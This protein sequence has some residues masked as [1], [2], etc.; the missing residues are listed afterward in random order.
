MT[1]SANASLAPARSDGNSARPARR[2]CFVTA[3][4]LTLQAFMRSHLERF[5]SFCEVTAVADFGPSDLGADDRIAGVERVPIAIPRA[6]SPW[7]DLCALL[8]L[9]RLFRRRRFDVVHSVTPKAGLLAMSAARA[10]GIP[11]R[12]HCFTGQVWATRTGLSRAMLRQADSLIAAQATR[13][14]VDSRSQLDFLEET[15]VL[16]PGQAA[17]LGHGSISG[18]D[19]ERFRPDAAAHA[20]VR[21]ELGVPAEAVLAVF[22]GRVTRD[23]GVLELAEAFAIAGGRHS[24]LWLLLVGPDEQ[25]LTTEIHRRAGPA[26][27]RLRMIAFTPRPERYL[28]AADI[29][30]LPSH[31]EGF[32][33]TVIEAAACG[34]PALA[35]RI[36]GLTDAVQDE[37][38]G[39]LHPPGDIFAIAAGLE[40]LIERPEQ[41]RSMGLAA[42]VRARR[43]F[44]AARITEELVAFYAR[45]LTA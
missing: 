4:P 24:D 15:G 5:A 26:E 44:S 40:Q 36:Y 31:R 41:R 16:R 39:I 42:A 28:A 7:A 2:I 29:L 10:A 3:A 33:T 9:H 38:T 34:V 43:D 45:E 32:G 12:V 35:S 22:V 11:C 21:A 27:S 8:H 20:E 13:V 17:V 19:L 18:V 37:V 1:R 23:K 25:G 30:C 6:I 14:L